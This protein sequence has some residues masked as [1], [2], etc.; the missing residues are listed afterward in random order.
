MEREEKESSEESDKTIASAER[1]K[2][3]RVANG[4]SSTCARAHCLMRRASLCVCVCG[5]L[6]E[7]RI[8]FTL[9]R[10]VWLE[11]SIERERAKLYLYIGERVSYFF[12]FLSR[13]IESYLS[14]F[15]FLVEEIRRLGR[16]KFTGWGAKSECIYMPTARWMVRG[17]FSGN[18]FLSSYCIV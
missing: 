2:K 1:K 18:Y 9:R 12:S 17:L 14:L 15:L 16:L 3:V 8:S 6:G 10:L 5:L 4:S 7:A 13:R 11:F